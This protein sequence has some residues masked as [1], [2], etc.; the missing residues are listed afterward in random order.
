MRF[1]ETEPDRHRLFGGGVLPGEFAGASAQRLAR[2]RL[3]SPAF[4]VTEPDPVRMTVRQRSFEGRIGQRPQRKHL[5]RTTSTSCA[6]SVPSNL[7]A[8]DR[9]ALAT[10][11][12][13]APHIAKWIRSASRARSFVLAHGSNG[14]VEVRSGSCMR[15]RA[16]DELEQHDAQRAH[17][18]R[19]STSRGSPRSCSRSSRPSVPAESSARVKHSPAVGSHGK[20]FERKGTST[21]TD[22]CRRLVTAIDAHEADLSSRLDR[23]F[24]DVTRWSAWMELERLRPALFPVRDDKA[25]QRYAKE[26]GKYVRG[27][28]PDL[29]GLDRVNAWLS[30]FKQTAAH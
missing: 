11:W 26:L 17:I 20:K 7:A 12:L 13:S 24:E 30:A 23:A 9:R 4:F 25:N 6:R 16:A 3:F 29:P 28:S 27:A 1:G 21:V 5:V 15:Q 19:T 18:C 10:S 22:Y 2:L 8:S 14:R